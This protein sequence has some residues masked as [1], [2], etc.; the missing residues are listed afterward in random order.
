VSHLRWRGSCLLAIAACARTP[1]P[2]GAV[3][4]L[5]SDRLSVQLYLIGDAGAPNPGGDPV[6][7]ALS[8]ELKADQ[9]RSVVVFLGDNIYPKGLPQPDQ[10]E[11]REAERR[12][13]AQIAT[14]RN[15]GAAGYFVLGN[16]DWARHTPDGWAAARRQEQFIDSAG[17]G[18]I[19]LK[20]QGGCPGPSVADIGA[21]LR[22][23]L[24]DTQWWLHTGPK[25]RDPTSSC[26]TDS[27]SEIVDSLHGSV[28]RAGNRL[29]VVVAHHPLR[30]GGVHGGYFGWK[31]HVFPLRLVASGL[32]LPLPLIGSLYPAARQNGISR[33]D[34]GSPAYQRLIAGFSRAFA[35][36]SPALYAAGHEH[37]LQVIAGGP[38]R[39]ELVSGGGYYGH[40]DRAVAVEGTKFVRKASGFA[41]L[42]VPLTGPARLAVLQ[43]DS[44]GSSREVFSTWVE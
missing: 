8:R 25:P 27:E 44:R 35:R 7:Q 10:P 38:A 37:N 19:T 40:S 24:L 20:P 36:A 22:L 5:A 12:L 16:H 6:L 26:P 29:V 42:D 32:W 1:P 17:G 13:S 28:S 39:L 43:V 41:R 4:A 2:G 30:T 33:Q 3:P 11:R 34:L 23:V 14:V 15:A 18:Q 9:S 31:D 21:R